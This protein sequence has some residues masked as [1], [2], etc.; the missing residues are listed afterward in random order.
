MTEKVSRK[1]LTGPRRVHCSGCPGVNTRW[2]QR[3]CL[4]CH[5]DAQHRYRQ[6]LLA[7]RRQLRAILRGE[8]VPGERRAA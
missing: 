8:R 3:Y 7:E 2:P 4:G 5:A 1:T 6:K